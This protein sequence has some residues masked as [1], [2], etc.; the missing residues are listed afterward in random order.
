MMVSDP[1]A[2]NTR[3]PTPSATPQTVVTPV[4][5]VVS[6]QHAIN[7]IIVLRALFP[8]EYFTEDTSQ[9]YHVFKI[10]SSVYFYI[11]ERTYFVMFL[12]TINI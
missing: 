3:P 4:V 5:N 2:N 12:K 10:L 9:R 11:Q 7:H 1:F 6:K 8:Q